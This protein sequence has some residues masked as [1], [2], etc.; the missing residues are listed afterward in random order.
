VNLHQ[1]ADAAP[2]AQC[3]RPANAAPLA[4]YFFRIFA[5]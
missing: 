1:R 5:S 4:R 2:L 3:H